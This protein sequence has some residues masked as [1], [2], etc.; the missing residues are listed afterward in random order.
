MVMYFFRLVF[1]F[2]FLFCAVSLWAVDEEELIARL[3]D[4]TVVENLGDEGKTNRFVD[5]IISWFWEDEVQDDVGDGV[6]KGTNVAYRKV[7]RKFKGTFFK[8][9]DFINEIKWSTRK[10][11]N[12]RRVSADQAF[13]VFGF[14]PYWMGNAY[15][16]Y[17]FELL[18]TISYFN[19]EV[20]PESGSYS[21]VDA[22]YNWKKTDLVEKA[23]EDSTRVL[24]TVANHGYEAN[25]TFLRNDITVHQA[26][27]DSL[28]NLIELKGADGVTV[29]FELVRR[30]DARRFNSFLVNLSTQL[31][32]RNAEYVMTVTLPAFDWEGVYDFEKLDGHVDRFVVMGYDFHTKRTAEG[33]IAPLNRHE[34]MKSLDL[35]GS[36]LSYDEAGAKRSD[37]IMAL[38]YYGGVWERWGDETE[39]V[40]HYSYTEV[41][42]RLEEENITP[43]LD[44]LRAS[45][46]FVTGEEGSSARQKVW[47]DNEQSLA[48]KYD[49]I[50]AEGFGGAGIWALGFDN[51]YNE[52]WQLIDEKFTEVEA[53]EA[54]SPLVRVADRFERYANL[55]IV[56]LVFMLLF[57]VLG[58][59]FS[60][61]DWRVREAFFQANQY[62]LIYIGGVFFLILAIFLAVG[63]VP[64]DWLK[65]FVGL[66]IG[67]VATFGVSFFV[68]K[69]RTSL[70]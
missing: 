60:L 37:L 52:L 3:Q 58:F 35:R 46:Y 23:H 63:Y 41:R 2:G 57:I 1:C 20:D 64:A 16:A 9:Y 36:L 70:P 47:F 22:I 33:P 5:A 31:K 21:N 68:R 61:T 28:I 39:F 55:I 51:G 69:W 62:R 42:Q 25:R 53:P 8:A 4:S 59:L 19:Y 38:P 43:I 10:Y 44:S 27:I 29:N 14:H 15:N 66:G 45:M 49:W 11:R 56:G 50:I 17:N 48:I 32:R 7:Q 26:L 40:D 34:D 54:Q 67:L 12:V 6:D 30:R 18:S 65:I 24:L 13:E